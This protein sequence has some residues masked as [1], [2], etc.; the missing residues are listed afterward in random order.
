MTPEEARS[1]FSEAAEN[2]LSSTEAKDFEETLASDPQLS[3]EYAAFRHALS[4]VGKLSLAD[5][6]EDV[7][8][9][10]HAV[11]T[12]LRKRSAG[13]YYRDRFS[14]EQR[15]PMRAMT[16]MVIAMLVAVMTIW[17]AIKVWHAIEVEEVPQRSAL[18]VPL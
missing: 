17:V 6:N 14:E 13:R 8:D 5:S 11:Q 10:L 15:V 18:D 3:Q 2:E 7:P 9:L 16:Y 4:E 12:R 1:K